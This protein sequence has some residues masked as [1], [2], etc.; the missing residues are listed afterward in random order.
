MIVL[1][2]ILAPTDFSEPAERALEYAKS[3]AENFQAVLHVVHVA[4]DVTLADPMLTA[5]SLAEIDESATS[6][7]ARIDER[8]TADERGRLEVRTSVLHGDPHDAILTYAA[9]NAI[10]LIVLGTHGRGTVERLILGSVAERIVRHA[11]CPVLT[12]KAEEPAAEG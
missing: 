9:E 11:K 6:A 4:A 3:I 5:S 12:V 1:R 2:S 10:E 7:L 8:L